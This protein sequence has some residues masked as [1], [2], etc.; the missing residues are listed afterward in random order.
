MIGS[1][2]PRRTL[3][4]QG[5]DRDR[6]RE[7]EPDAGAYRPERKTGQQH[8]PEELL[9]DMRM[10]PRPRQGDN[11]NADRGQQHRSCRVAGAWGAHSVTIP[12]TARLAGSSA[13]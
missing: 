8:H 3:P 11:E 2:G 12:V 9:G 1:G 5:A 13:A 7:P 6:Q 10:R 4:S